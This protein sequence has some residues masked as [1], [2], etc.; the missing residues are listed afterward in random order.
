MYQE[1][2]LLGN[3]GGDPTLRY[4]PERDAGDL[5]QG[6]DEPPLA[7]QGWDDAGKNGLVRRY[8]DGTAG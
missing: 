6:S 8:G 7:G 2:V 4:T 5:F 1:I 3:L